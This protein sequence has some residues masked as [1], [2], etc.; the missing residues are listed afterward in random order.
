[1]ITTGTI[2]RAYSQNRNGIRQYEVILEDI[3]LDRACHGPGHGRRA[4]P[5]NSFGPGTAHGFGFDSNP[6]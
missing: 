1:M 6:S 3:E 4:G 5:P 2:L